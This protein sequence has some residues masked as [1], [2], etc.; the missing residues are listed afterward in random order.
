MYHHDIITF[1]GS[2][3]FSPPSHL[4]H[5]RHDLTSQIISWYW[6]TSWPSCL[7]SSPCLTSRLWFRSWHFLKSQP[8]WVGLASHHV[9]L[10]SWVVKQQWPSIMVPYHTNSEWIVTFLTNTE[11]CIYGVSMIPR[12]GW[13]HHSTYHLPMIT[14]FC[15]TGVRPLLTIYEVLHLTLHF[16]LLLNEENSSHNGARLQ[17][18]PTWVTW[19]TNEK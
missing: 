17:A 11:K 16:S 6:F 12:T 9:H 2:L 8:S 5:A 19:S 7:I 1:C 18:E 3:M 15:Q 13:R 4:A 14:E 10:A